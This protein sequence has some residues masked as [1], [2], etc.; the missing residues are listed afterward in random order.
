[1]IV[2][3]EQFKIIQLLNVLLWNS[4]YLLSPLQLE[5]SWLIKCTYS[6]TIPLI[7]ILLLFSHVSF[8][9]RTTQLFSWFW[10]KIFRCIFI[11]SAFYIPCLIIQGEE[12][13]SHSSTLSFSFSF[14]IPWIYSA[15]LNYVAYPFCRP[16]HFMEVKP[17]IVYCIAK[18]YKTVYH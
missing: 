14:S 17:G 6:Q 4:L 8:G 9:L 2:V 3:L 16:S 11:A 13:S 7:C 18:M 15:L 5:L 12:Q 10:T 1:V